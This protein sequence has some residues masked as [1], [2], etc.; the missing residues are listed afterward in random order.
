MPHAAPS[1]WPP[2]PPRRSCRRG[3]ALVE[4]ALVAPLLLLLLAGILDYGQALS[5]A[6]A[7][8]NAAR[9]GAQYAVSSRARSSDT[10]G[11]RAAVIDSS[12]G[13]SG[14]T[15]DTVR[16]CLCPGGSSVNC[17]GTCGA[18]AMQTYVRVTVTA[19]SSPIFSYSGLPFTGNVKG[20][21][22]MRAQ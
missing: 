20:Q 6:T 14:L 17:A 13:F 12:P 5:K 2:P 19:A 22:T 4:F 18:A 9:I 10:A 8:A 16:S 21:A 3:S 11:I 1:R 7:V 15:V